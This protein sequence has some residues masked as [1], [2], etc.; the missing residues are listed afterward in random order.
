[1]EGINWNLA[2]FNTNSKD[3]ILFVGTSTSAGF[4]TNYGETRRRGIELGLNGSSSRLNWFV[5]L[6]YIDATFQSDACLL[7]ENNSSRGT[8]PFCTDVATGVG[9]DLIYVQKREQDSGHSG[10]PGA[11]LRRVSTAR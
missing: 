2:F 11:G 6:S 7:S 8:S 1:M 3:D 9:D 5:N 4:F 10:N